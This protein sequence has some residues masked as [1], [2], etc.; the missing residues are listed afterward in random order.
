MSASATPTFLQPSLLLPRITPSPTAPVD[1]VVVELSTTV[2]IP[3]YARFYAQIPLNSFEPRYTSLPDGTLASSAFLDD[4]R[5]SYTSLLVVALVGSVAL[6]NILV[7]VDYLRRANFKRR[8][9]FYLL[10]S[11]QIL[12]LGLAPFIA[13]YFNSSLD[14]TAVL[15]VAGGS[16]GIALALLMS[17]IL[18]LKAY[19]CLDSSRVV[20]FIL[21]ALCGASTSFLIL[22]LASLTGVRRLSGGCSSVSS[23]PQ[24]IRIYVLIQLLHSFFLCCCFFY[25]VWKSRASPAFRGRLSVRVSLDDF[26]G[27]NFDKPSPAKW[28]NTLLGRGNGTNIPPALDIPTPTASDAPTRTTNSAASRPRRSP[29]LAF[30]RNNVSDPIMEEPLVDKDASQPRPR[31]TSLLR[32]IPRVEL[33]HDVMKDELL[34]T[35]T[36]MVTTVV[37]AVLVV[38]GVNIEN[39]LD[40]PSW[41]SVNAAIVS[42]LVIDSFGRVVRRH[43]REALLQQQTPGWSAPDRSPYPRRG[44]PASPFRAGVSASDDPFSD[45]SAVLRDSLSSWKSELTTAS[46]V[47]PIPAASRDRRSSLPSTSPFSERASKRESSTSSVDEKAVGI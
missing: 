46:P 2:L 47:S 17:G 29:G 7:C 5:S 32:L 14:C 11:S 27:V 35:T 33:F 28:W 31:P 30:W 6:R 23:N 41:L 43:E 37:L 8:M 21:I 1:Q 24:F 12:S 3:D 25:A 44:F 45:A 34:Y 16:T 40:L 42:L 15:G 13:S 22:H 9:L 20:L 18:G 26:P 39:S 4:L 19:R 36:I 38:L 10:L